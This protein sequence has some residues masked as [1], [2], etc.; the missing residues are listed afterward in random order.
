M[1]GIALVHPETLDGHWTSQVLSIAHVREPTTVANLP[2]VYKFRLENIRG[3]Y[4][5]L[6]FTDLGKQ[7]Q[8]PLLEFV[9]EACLRKN[10][11]QVPSVPGDG[12]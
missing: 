7:P 10:L 3:G 8:A 9:I 11:Y 6:S 5:V 2:H 1:V 12:V 4:D